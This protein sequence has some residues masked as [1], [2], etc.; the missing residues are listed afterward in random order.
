MS[1]TFNPAGSASVT[2]L[3]TSPIGN[4]LNEWA[5][6]VSGEWT[7]SFSP[8]T[9]P[10]A[11]ALGV[12]PFVQPSGGNLAATR[13]LGGKAVEASFN[14]GGVSGKTTVS[15]DNATGKLR[16]STVNSDGTVTTATI[17]K[18]GTDQWA[19]DA[20]CA[21]VSGSLE[22]STDIIS[23][24]DGGNTLNHRVTNRK[25]NG[26]AEPDLLA[27][28]KRK[29]NVASP[30]PLSPTHSATAIPISGPNLFNDYANSIV[31][32]W[33]TSFAPP[34]TTTAAGVN[35]SPF[36]N[37]TTGNL[38]ATRIVGGTAIEATFNLG[39]ISGKTTVA[40]DSST[41]KLH[42]TTVNSDGSR[43]EAYITSLGGGQ[44]AAAA[45]CPP[46][47]AAAGVA[48]TSLDII[49]ITDWGN[50]QIHHMTN[51]M[52][53]DGQRL[54]DLNGVF[55]RTSLIA[56]P[57]PLNPLHGAT[58]TSTGTGSPMMIEWGNTVGGQWSVS[59]S[60]SVGD[61]SVPSG[62]SSSANFIM[63]TVAL[64][65]TF[66]MGSVSGKWTAAD[67]DKGQLR[68][69]TVNSDGSTAVAFIQKLGE[70][71]YAMNQACN[72]ADGSQET[73]TDF[74]SVSDGGNTL[75]H[76]VTNRIRDGKQEPDMLGVYK[77]TAP[78]VS[79]T[80]A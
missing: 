3:T 16:Q 63:G 30:I 34:A 21:A 20:T 13:I 50:T 64:E 23:V 8:S 24:A 62:G 76:R 71:Q 67:A 11:S 56:T 73:S 26:L 4:L 28:F 66:N 10:T 65:G 39:G 44:F 59:F 29:S 49:T 48:A 2:P 35:I 6:L 53:S 74:I 19:V 60:G 17:T 77:R 47:Y 15:L 25:L 32:Q 51:R 31:G 69:D 37:P 70:G 72:F 18:I 45:D 52:T 80:T 57:I 79:P 42:Q 22:T 40:M 78:L 38:A 33:T 5:S 46:E 54:P 1:S 43:V 14:L 58:A 36:V 7:M 12:G 27:T 41:G 75:T 68:Q 61:K 55:K 9:A